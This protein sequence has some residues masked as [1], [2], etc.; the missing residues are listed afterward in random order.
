MFKQNRQN[1]AQTTLEYAIL[2]GVIVAGLIAM[3]IYLK[4]GYQGKLRESADSMGQQFSA[5]ETT[6]DYGS[7]SYTNSTE[8]VT[9]GVTTSTIKAQNSERR[10]AERVNDFKKEQK[11]GNWTDDI[12]VLG[13]DPD[14]LTAGT[15]PNVDT[16][17]QGGTGSGAD[18]K[19]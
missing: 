16:L 11:W 15:M 17:P 5:G 9:G 7:T 12:D 1:K 19:H 13:I 14:T 2:I 18:N 8:N 6:M 10:G 4:R 3:Q